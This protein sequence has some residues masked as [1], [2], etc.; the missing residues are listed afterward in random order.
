MYSFNDLASL[1][2]VVFTSVS[3]EAEASVIWG[4]LG[5]KEDYG[6]AYELMRE[7]HGVDIRPMLAPQFAL[8]VSLV[9]DRDCAFDWEEIL[10]GDVLLY[11]GLTPK[12]R[13]LAVIDVA[14]DSLGSNLH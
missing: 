14:L 2:E 1:R 9:A 13:F 7:R 4:A 6:L 11:Q 5:W 10:E 12:Q 3:D 8:A